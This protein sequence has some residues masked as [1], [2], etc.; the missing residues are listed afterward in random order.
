MTAA[1]IVAAVSV[2]GDT[3]IN[4]EF[5]IRKLTTNVTKGHEPVSVQGVLNPQGITQDFLLISVT[6]WVPFVDVFATRCIS[7]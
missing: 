4:Q 3:V 6:L 5:R 7:P 2:T 1:A